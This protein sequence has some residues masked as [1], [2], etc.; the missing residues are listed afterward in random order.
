VAADRRFREALAIIPEVL[1]I[2]PDQ[3]FSKVRKR[4]KGASQY[5]RLAATGQ[6]HEVGEG[7]C[8]F[9][10]NFTDY[11][12]TGLFLDHRPTRE[13][14]RT[15][16]AGKR[17]LNLFA[18]TGTATVHA[19]AGG[20]VATT[21]VDLSSTYLDWARRN[22]ELNG[23]V[24]TGHELVR[25]ECREWL[26]KTVNEGKRRWGLIFLDPPSFSNSKRMAGTFDVQR[27]H[28]V[29]I[30]QAVKLL[31]PDGILI[32]STNLQSFA[33]D[34]GALAGLILEDLT[35]A[36][37]PPDYRRNPHIHSCWRI[38]P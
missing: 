10:V 13:L 2:S 32:F 30:G 4:Q 1:G 14:L 21:T 28:A 23:F 35:T 31:A 26:E 36:T 20:A 16:A 9:L 11:L 12:D 18:Y 7:P 19:A 24:G 29:L 33:L 27:D 5:T 25:A 8:R 17:F 3:L 22:L 15:L 6:F 34:T 38:T 37:I